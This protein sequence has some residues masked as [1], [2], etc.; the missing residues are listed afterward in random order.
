MEND[1]RDTQHLPGVPTED[2]WGGC[3]ECGKTDGFVNVNCDHYFICQA[4]RTKWYVGSNL[5]SFWK[6]ETEEEQRQN[7][8]R[9]GF[10]GFRH[11]EPVF[12]TATSQQDASGR[13]VGGRWL[14][15]ITQERLES[16]HR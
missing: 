15:P 9:L 10:S 6:F 13:L 4:H 11:V 12:P 14:N 7:C 2:Y 3:P 16:N 8:E 1:N 5:F